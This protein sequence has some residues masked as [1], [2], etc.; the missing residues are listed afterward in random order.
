[1]LFRSDAS[2]ITAALPSSGGG[3]IPVQG[4]G[5]GGTVVLQFTAP[6]AGG[7]DVITRA[8]VDAL[9]VAAGRGLLPSSLRAVTS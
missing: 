6:L 8:V 3:R 9:G 7:Q 5:G 2:G 1:V 4:G